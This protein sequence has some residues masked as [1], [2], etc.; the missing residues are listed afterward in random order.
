MTKSPSR[1]KL[2]GGLFI[3]GGLAFFAAAYFA[4]QVTFVGVGVLFMAVGAT[5][6][7]RAGMGA[8]Q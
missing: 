6:L 4:R 3:A 7:K 2:A 1:A 8:D 5:W